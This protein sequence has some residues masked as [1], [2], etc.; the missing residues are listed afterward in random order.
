MNVSKL[1]FKATVVGDNSSIQERQDEEDRLKKGCSEAS[2]RAVDS[3]GNSV[4]LSFGGW[5]TGS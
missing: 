2:V 3:T 5:V 1:G 4:S